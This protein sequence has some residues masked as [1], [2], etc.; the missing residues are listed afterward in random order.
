M[1]EV[2]VVAHPETGEPVIEEKSYRAIELD[3]ER[4]KLSE[5]QAQYEEKSA[6]HQALG[7]ELAALESAVE[8]QKSLVDQAS[9]LT[10]EPVD[11]SGEAGDGS[12]VETDGASA[13]SVEPADEPAGDTPEATP[14]VV[15]V[16]EDA[17]EY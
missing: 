4:T 15:A 10:P 11:P 16:V 12:E 6:A 7:Q 9:S 8:G 17:D 5:L 1:S 2:K 13:D 14:V 3:Q